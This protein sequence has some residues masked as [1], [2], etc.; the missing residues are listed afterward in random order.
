[1]WYL[2]VSSRLGDEVYPRRDVFNP[3]SHIS[4][5]KSSGTCFIWSII[6]IL[7]GVIWDIRMSR[8]ILRGE[9]SVRV[10]FQIVVME[11]GVAAISIL[12]S[13][14]WDFSK[15]ETIRSAI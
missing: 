9:E 7:F 14:S 4:T 5:M 6:L 12:S 8:V 15:F 13:S 10:V 2:Q 1:M 11:V 3:H